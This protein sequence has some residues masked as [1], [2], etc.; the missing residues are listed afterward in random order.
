MLIEEIIRN[1]LLTQT[2]IT[3]PVYI[4]V[5]SNPPAARIVIERTGGG[6][7]EHI[8]NNQIAIQSYGASRYKAAFIHE[9]VLTVM[10]HIIALPVI[11]ACELNA[12][13]DFT[14]TETKEFRYQ[15]VF[16]ITHYGG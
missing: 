14:D 11:S 5:P 2:A 8:R 9:A 13:Y 15:A 4:D 10:Q 16:D 12:E 1:Y 6:I 3:A 7:E